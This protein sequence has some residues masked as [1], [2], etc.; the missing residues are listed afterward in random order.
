[1]KK[2]IMLMITAVVAM[3][4]VAMPT[5]SATTRPVAAPRVAPAT[6]ALTLQWSAA[7]PCVFGAP[8]NYIAVYAQRDVIG[9]TVKNYRVKTGTGISGVTA[10][11]V[12]EKRGSTEIYTG[13]LANVPAGQNWTSAVT[14]LPYMSAGAKRYARVQLLRPS[15]LINKVCEVSILIGG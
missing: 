7:V 2:K 11:N 13:G 5:A 3:I 12:W 10:A 9:T 15:A 6:N 1:M 4:A 14:R 8:E